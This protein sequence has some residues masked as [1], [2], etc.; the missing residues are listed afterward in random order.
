[1]SN[2]KYKLQKIKDSVMPVTAK[3]KLA[4][5]Q[6]R[7][8]ISELNKKQVSSTGFWAQKRKELFAS[9]LNK[10]PRRFLEWPVMY[11][12]FFDPNLIEL[13]YLMQHKNWPQIKSA[14]IEDAIGRPR[15]WKDF[16]KS[17]GNLIH[18]AYTLQKY[19]DYSEIQLNDLKQ[20][21]EFGGGYGSFCRL[22]YKMGFTG[23]YII[24]DLPEYSAIQEY[25]LS[26]VNLGLKLSVN[27]ISKVEFA[28][29]LINNMEKLGNGE[30]YD[31]CVGLWSLS[32]CPLELRKS[33]FKSI[34][35]C[36][37]FLIGFQEKFETIDNLNYFGK[38]ISFPSETSIFPID[39]L[40]GNYYLF[41][42]L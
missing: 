21:I 25:F 35:G 3:E 42:K 20:I 16:P 38:D 28:V 27:E 19:L 1:M 8:R 14:I 22:I 10:D 26:G 33:F 32:E 2:L 4:I 6:L 30:N 11:P 5:A 24:Y 37:R 12:M 17:S 34:A 40:P 7:E 41:S 23:S 15:P 31:L 9:V 36:N 18:H 13:D 29:S 39:H